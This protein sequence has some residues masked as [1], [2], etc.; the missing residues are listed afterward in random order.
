MNN[1]QLDETPEDDELLP[2][3]LMTG[4]IWATGA[5]LAGAFMLSITNQQVVNGEITSFIDYGA[6]AGGG[7]ALLLAAVAL[8][9]ALSPLAGR[10]K[11][12]RLG[13]I[14]VL[15]LLAAFRLL[16]GLGMFV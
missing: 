6:I 5:A 9:D 3:K 15:S 10:Q 14:G 13:I 11:M 8:K 12:P 7:L 2:Q 1:T 16:Y 4:S